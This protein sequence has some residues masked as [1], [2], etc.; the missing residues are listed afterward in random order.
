MV[1][2]YIKFNGK[3]FRIN[4]NPEE[5]I[6][7]QSEYKYKIPI[8]TRNNENLPVPDEILESCSSIQFQDHHN[9]PVNIEDVPDLIKQ[10]SS[11]CSFLLNILNDDKKDANSCDSNDRINPTCFIEFFN[12]LPETRRFV[13]FLFFLMK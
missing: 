9:L 4:F 12:K 10:F 11:D 7:S 13:A 6:I 8:E 2:V 1:F 5:H 3:T